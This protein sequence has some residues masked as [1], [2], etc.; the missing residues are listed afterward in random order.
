MTN[1]KMLRQKIEDSGLKISEILK[2]IGIKSYYTLR[3][4][5]ENRKE[6]TASEIIKLCEIL[7]LSNEDREAIF[8]ANDVE[9]YSA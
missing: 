2:R 8:F 5:I 1:T 4:K 6:F 9:L 7:H 3:E